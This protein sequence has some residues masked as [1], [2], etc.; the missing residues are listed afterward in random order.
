MVPYPAP[1][2]ELLGG[3]AILVVGY[4]DSIQR[5]IC[6]NSW[7]IS[8]GDKGFFYMP[9]SYFSNA[10]LADDFWTGTLAL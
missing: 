6:Q 10:N 4:D 2:E 5:F 9:Y 1:N 8:W 3:H 7:G